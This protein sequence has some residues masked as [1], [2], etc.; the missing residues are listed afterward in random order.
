MA[1][2]HLEGLPGNKTC[3]YSVNGTDDTHQER[4]TNT[5]QM[6]RHGL[7]TL[8]PIWSLL[9]PGSQRPSLSCVLQPLCRGQMP[10]VLTAPPHS[11]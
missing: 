9:A 8:E 7:K 5:K 2:D 10:A 4:N 11:I 1:S 6:L 3:P